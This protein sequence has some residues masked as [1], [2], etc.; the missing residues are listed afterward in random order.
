MGFAI[1]KKRCTVTTEFI[2]TIIGHDNRQGGL[3]HDL[4]VLLVIALFYRKGGSEAW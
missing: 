4:P 2:T 1:P 3:F